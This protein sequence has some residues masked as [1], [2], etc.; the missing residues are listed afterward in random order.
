MKRLLLA[1][2]LM[3]AVSVQAQSLNEKFVPVPRDEC[4]A[5]TVAIVDVLTM[6]HNQAKEVDQLLIANGAKLSY[7]GKTIL[8]DFVQIVYAE[9]DWGDLAKRIAT[10]S[11]FAARWQFELAFTCSSSDVWPLL[12]ETY[13]K[14][15]TQS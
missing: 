4:S 7:E 11:D 1:I 13:T 5:L 9:K 15:L 6:Y 2:G 14:P 12:Y 3:F 8:R 10:D